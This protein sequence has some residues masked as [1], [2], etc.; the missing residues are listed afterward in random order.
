MRKYKKPGVL[1][2]AFYYQDLMAIEVLIAF[3]RDRHLYQWVQLDAEDSVYASIDD[4]VACRADGSLELLQV[5]F[6]PDPQAAKVA[7]SWEWLLAKTIRGRSL[8]QKWSGT[9]QRHVT[10]GTLA[11]ASLKTDRI[12]E[13]AFRDAL[14][15]TRISYDKVSAQVRQ[16]IEDQVGG[17]SVA[18]AFFAAFDFHH[19]LPI[20]EDLEERLRADV[21]FDI[22]GSTW[23]NFRELVATWATL[24]NSPEPDGKVRHSHLRQA[25]S[26]SRPRPI[27]QDF[28]IPSG[29]QPP[30]EAF[31]AGFVN[32][33]G[34]DGIKVLVGPPGRG[35]S[36]Y[37]SHC[38]RQLSANRTVCIRHHYF[39]SLTDRTAG[40]FHANDITNSLCSQLRSQLP[41]AGIPDADLSG[42]IAAAAK[43]VKG[44]GLRLLIVIDGIDH[45]W[46]ENRSTAHM[47]QIFSEILP[48]PPGVTLAVGTQPVPDEYI[49]P[50]LL[51]LASREKWT[52]LPLMSAEVVL[53]WLQEQ[54][55]AGRLQLHVE[56]KANRVRTL[57]R[58]ASA[59]HGISDG[60]PLHLIYA[61]ESLSRRGAPLTVEMVE[62]IPPCPDGDIRI[63]Y[64]GLWSGIGRRAQEILHILATLKFA[65]PPSGLRQCLG[66]T[67]EDHEAL[68]RIDH[69]LDHRE[70]GVYPFHG[71]LFAFIREQP[72]S[73]KALELEGANVVAWLEGDAPTF[74]KW[75]WLWLTKAQLGDDS[76]LRLKPDRSWVIEAM[77]AAYPLDQ[78]VEILDA[79]AEAV[80]AAF[81]LP[82]ALTLR[83]LRIRL[84]N[85]AEMQV[86]DWQA[87][88]AAALEISTDSHVTTALRSSLVD[89]EP[90]EMV[91]VLRKVQDTERAF[92]ARAAVDQVNERLRLARLRGRSPREELSDDIAA[93]VAHLATL[94]LEKLAGFFGEFGVSKK[95][96]TLYAREAIRMDE[97]AKVIDV[98]SFAIE[99][100]FAD[101]LFAAFCLEARDPFGTPKPELKTNDLRLYALSA[102]MGNTP[103]V[104]LEVPDYNLLFGR[105]DYTDAG[106]Q[107]HSLL[108]DLF[109]RTFY[110][111]LIGIESPLSLDG[112]KPGEHGWLIEPLKNLHEMATAIAVA[113]RDAGE[114]PTMAALYFGLEA[115][116]TPE[117]GHDTFI[118]FGH[119]R[120][121]IT[122]ISIDLQLL[123]HAL[124]P[125]HFIVAEDIDTASASPLWVAETWVEKFVSRGLILHTADA[126]TRVLD[127]LSKDLAKYVKQF[128]DRT[129]LCVKLSQFAAQHGLHV[130]VA[131]FLGQAIGGIL[132]YGWRKD[133][134][135]SEVLTS[136]E[137]LHDLDVFDI[138]KVLVSLA[139][140]FDQITEYT[141]GDETDHIKTDF[142][143]LLAR[144]D[145]ERASLAY[146]YLI[147]KE[148]WRYADS[149]L[150][151][152]ARWLPAGPRR[153]HL[154]QTF[155]QPTEFN[156][157]EK[158]AQEG[159]LEANE[160]LK[161]VMLYCGR[162]AQDEERE[163]VSSKERGVVT[164]PSLAITAYGPHEL[165]SFL[166]AVAAL[167][168][169]ARRGLVE[170]WFEHW[171][172]VGQ[173]AEVLASLYEVAVSEEKHPD[174]SALYDRAFEI[175]VTYQGRSAGYKW[176]V[177]AHRHNYG[178]QLF[179]SRG[180]TATD[181]LDLVAKYYKKRWRDFIKDTARLTRIRHEGASFALGQSRLVYF[182]IKV[183][184]VEDAVACTM[185]LVETLR[186][187]TAVQPLPKLEW[188]S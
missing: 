81:D 182:L 139:P 29:Y 51:Q 123:G 180:E 177:L 121:A 185:A 176:L 122:A 57:R 46:R 61:F 100:E 70:L 36:T 4:V 172:S 163:H 17:E 101:E 77:S 106:V 26:P 89:L 158:N 116:T 109:F 1:R 30:S 38:V 40:R 168:W 71:S 170:N 174:L 7:L 86:S 184:Q 175:A 74:W 12:P 166:D 80:F 117:G 53:Q 132:G 129:D 28:I 148:E 102:M 92:L 94:D 69:L 76:D 178:W 43:A 115:T 96:F 154:L 52:E 16:L 153:A 160:A 143:S 156:W 55:Q 65:F 25:L 130:A 68:A 111:E 127:Q 186:A 97:P 149:L 187:E 3:F 155:I 84:E 119:L 128:S 47:N 140:I 98:A 27:P 131:D 105:F 56:P 10:S 120:N 124:D 161:S 173:A 88:H 135:A 108:S 15:G 133:M 137:Y 48:L 104:L 54:D 11:S 183:G 141:D 5:K 62:S 49:P 145:V 9:L 169:E 24:K 103:P 33:L 32:A 179:M 42:A 147:N 44:S 125:E 99:P 50:R 165:K 31:H 13:A 78:I 118:L 34:L 60:L 113:W 73:E 112:L 64:S 152:L 14:V 23:A 67:P 21:A 19:S 18:R 66:R 144:V 59:F 91:T 151:D 93:L 167:P 107:I 181:R 37:L 22:D 72:G 41:N 157:L 58:V 82:R 188:A 110:S 85:G 162:T 6:T 87:F 63:Y 114:K 136:L 90:W 142:Y 2:A 159:D 146:G 75:A 150:L 134:F 79:A 35:K 20:L 171:T 39:L 83:L 138:V 126:A 45:V 8:I 164:S 95:P